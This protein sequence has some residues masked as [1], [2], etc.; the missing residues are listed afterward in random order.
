MISASTLNRAKRCLYWASVGAVK[1]EPLRVEGQN[2]G[3]EFHAFAERFFSDENVRTADERI[4]NYIFQ[5]NTYVLRQ[6]W[7]TPIPELAFA[8]N[9]LTFGAVVLGS[10]LNRDYSKFSLPKSTVFGTADLVNLGETI[11]ICDYK[12]G[13][14]V[15]LAATSDQLLFL[16]LCANTV[17]KKPVQVQIISFPNDEIQISKFEPQEEDYDRLRVELS[18]IALRLMGSD[19]VPVSG[20]HCKST[21]CPL[22][23]A[24]PAT[25]SSLDRIALAD[26]KVVFTADEI[27][28]PE[29]AAWLYQT[30]RHTQASAA[31]LFD[32]V[33]KYTEIH[34]E[35]E[36]DGKTIGTSTHT[37][38]QINANDEVL[39]WLGN[40]FGDINL[41]PHLKKSLTSE[42][43]HQLCRKKAIDNGL[44]ISVVEKEVYAALAN[45]DGVKVT[46]SEKWGEK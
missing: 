27:E 15:P 11:A 14:N 18:T 20:E 9:P 17:F 5:L 4:K 24:C 21:Y 19:V 38:K 30:A 3:T 33:R 42:S 43:L 32:A 28:S 41:E 16:A 22:F 29:H 37:R 46:T 34:G 45:L 36:I 31:R 12:T 25:R 35:L 7:R 13:H 44:R 10:R 23:G 8:Y 1:T 2:F 40:F 26:H 39:G 6:K